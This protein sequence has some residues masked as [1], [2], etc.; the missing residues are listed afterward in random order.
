MENG[1]QF[2]AISPMSKKGNS[3]REAALAPELLGQAVEK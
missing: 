1:T 3:L 2:T